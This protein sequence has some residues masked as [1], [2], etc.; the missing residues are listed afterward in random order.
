MRARL[1]I[2]KFTEHS[3]PLKDMGIGNPGVKKFSE[4]LKSGDAQMIKLILK[5]FG[6]KT[7][8]IDTSDADPH[9]YTYAPDGHDIKAKAYFNPGYI[10]VSV[11]EKNKF[12]AELPESVIE[13]GY[14]AN[15]HIDRKGVYCKVDFMSH[16]D[17]I[18]R[19]AFEGMD[20]QYI[21]KYFTGV[22][23]R[24]NTV[25]CGGIA[26]TLDYDTTVKEIIEASYERIE[27]NVIDAYRKIQKKKKK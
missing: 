8:L 11:E 9:V 14:Y 17:Q 21:F 27:K 22:S 3:D 2:E 18:A 10:F 16:L 24:G 13:K 5:Y 15:Q 6:D 23:M 4:A 26:L 7:I 25:I 19:K 12:K 1:I 20:Q